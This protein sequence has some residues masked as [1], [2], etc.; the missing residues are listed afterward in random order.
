MSSSRQAWY[1]EQRAIEEQIK[2][3]QR[4]QLA[5]D[6]FA[7]QP[8]QLSLGLPIPREYEIEQAYY[9]LVEECRNLPGWRMSEHYKTAARLGAI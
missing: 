4:M 6:K 8:E 3:D 2:E 7:K 9:K 1:E 5:R